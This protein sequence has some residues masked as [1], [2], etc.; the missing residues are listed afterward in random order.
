MLRAKQANSSWA[1]DVLRATVI[2]I[3]GDVIFFDKRT[4]K[5]FKVSMDANAA[6]LFPM[7]YA[8]NINDVRIENMVLNG[9]GLHNEHIN[10]NYA[11]A[12]FIQYCNRWSFKNVTAKDYNGDGFS[13]QVCD[14]IHFELQ[15][16]SC[17]IQSR[18]LSERRMAHGRR[19]L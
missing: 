14:D 10:G 2:D 7:I 12:V 5:N 8:E 9:N 1:L 4:E 13:F 17:I 15:G 19:N 16:M 3:R 6:T 11:G 18:Y